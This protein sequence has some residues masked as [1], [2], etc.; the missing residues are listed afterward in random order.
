MKKQNV[1]SIT[2]FSKNKG[3][4][5]LQQFQKFV[6][7]RGAAFF[8]AKRLACWISIPQRCFWNNLW[9]FW[10]SLGGIARLFRGNQKQEYEDTPQDHK[11]SRLNNIEL[12]AV[13]FGFP[14]PIASGVARLNRRS[15]AFHFSIFRNGATCEPL[16]L[17]LANIFCRFCW[18]DLYY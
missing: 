7:L 6:L 2:W 10:W 15:S 14:S 8:F 9:K 4:L 1:L 11:W 12:R 17:L 16:W 3:P 5:L 18:N 13:F